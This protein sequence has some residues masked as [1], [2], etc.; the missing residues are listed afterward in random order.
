MDRHNLPV[1]ALAAGPAEHGDG[2]RQDAGRVRGV[3]GRRHSEGLPV[4][5]VSLSPFPE[6]WSQLPAPKFLP[7]KP[8]LKPIARL[9]VAQ[10]FDIFMRSLEM[11]SY[12]LAHT[13]LELEKPDVIIRPQ[14]G[15]IGTLDRVDIVELADRGDA[16]VENVLPQLHRAVSWPL[17]SA[18][19][20]AEWH[21]DDEVV[22]N[23]IE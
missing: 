22:E 21:S 3:Q 17:I 12:M 9:R 2:E 15:D 7:E 5:A 10:A 4:V 16:A 1:G 6:T 20:K 23:M 19:V 8:I 14:V 11:G 13:R 18:L